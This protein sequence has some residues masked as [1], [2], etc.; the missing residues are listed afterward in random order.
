MLQIVSGRAQ[1]DVVTQLQNVIPHNELRFCTRIHIYAL[2]L[3]SKRDTW[4]VVIDYRHD[5]MGKASIIIRRCTFLYVQ[6][7]IS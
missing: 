7:E 6:V 3:H 5:H 4:E 1:A 2:F